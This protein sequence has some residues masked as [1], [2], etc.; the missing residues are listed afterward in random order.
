MCTRTTPLRAVTLPVVL[1][2]TASPNARA[3]AN[4]RTSREVSRARVTD[5]AVNGALTATTIAAMTMS[6]LRRFIAQRRSELGCGSAQAVEAVERHHNHTAPEYRG[7]V[8]Q[9]EE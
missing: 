4:V 9:E 2:P 1:Q 7:H 3:A 6:A 8:G 5:V